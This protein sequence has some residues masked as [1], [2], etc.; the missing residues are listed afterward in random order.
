M[1]DLSGGGDDDVKVED[2]HD[3]VDHE[4]RNRMR[5]R[6]VD[7]LLQTEQ[8]YLTNLENLFNIFILPL[9][10][11]KLL[12]TSDHSLIFPSDLSTIYALHMQL[13][14]D[15]Q[16]SCAQYNNES[17]SIGDIFITYGELFKMYQDYFNKYEVA[18]QHLI[19][20][21][22]QNSKFAE[23]CAQELPKV[24]GLTI[25]SF[26][27]LPIQRLPRYELLLREIIKH[28]GQY[29]VDRYAL[30]EANDQIMEITELINDRLKEHDRRQ[31]VMR[32]EQRFIDMMDAIG[33]LVKPSRI[34]IAE[35][36][37]TP[38][39]DDYCMRHD[40]YGNRIPI[41]LFLF[42]DC[43]IYG[44]Y[45]FYRRNV[46]NKPLRH[47]KL[48]FGSILLFDELFAVR[49]P[50]SSSAAA[51]GNGDYRQ[52]ACL[53]ILS[54]HHS[55]W[56]S[57]HS[58]SG[59][60]KWRTLITQQLQ[61]RE[62]DIQC[63]MLKSSAI[64]PKQ[65]FGQQPQ[66]PHIPS[67]V[68]VPDDYCEVCM[69]CSAKF[70]VMLRRHHCYYCG[71]LLCYDCTQKK[72]VDIWKL[73]FAAKKEYIR[74]C[75]NCYANHQ[76][77]AVREHNEVST[78]ENHITNKSDDDDDDDNHDSENEHTPKLEPKLSFLCPST[79]DITKQHALTSPRYS[80]RRQRIKDKFKM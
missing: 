26:L 64:N 22:R 61:R 68:F 39:G 51:G 5:K 59:K 45:E 7:E 46:D 35:S 24:R 9:K 13:N 71:M 23:W 42:N 27:I 30:Q 78:D 15:F 4:K 56:V 77:D 60:N 43:L 55:I 6:A 76:Q 19:K 50:P 67:P 32:I 20:L 52:L 48:R 25:Q 70:G 54:A 63:L 14:S 3:Q 36:S 1:T 47:G 18:V 21:E 44:F 69:R 66:P 11:N 38:N 41:T 65:C 72:L 17:T 53:S 79:I 73:Y 80:K 74:V 8:T 75:D 62:H 37:E 34:F 58:Q 16:Q 2:Q 57:F 49:D 28:T 33:T 40:K 31:K 12:T 10:S 29:H